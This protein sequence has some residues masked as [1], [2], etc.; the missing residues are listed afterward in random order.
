DLRGMFVWD[1]DLNR[2]EAAAVNRLQ[3]PVSEFLVGSPIT[4]DPETELS[5][6]IALMLEHGIGAVPVIHPHSNDLVGI[7]SY[8][9]VLRGLQD[10]A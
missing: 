9:D 4:V 5:D 8:V 2:F 10:I 1:P 6:V 7:I 3:M